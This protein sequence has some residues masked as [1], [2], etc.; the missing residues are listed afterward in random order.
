MD[1]AVQALEF[2]LSD[3]STVDHI[4]PTWL[5]LGRYWTVQVLSL[6]YA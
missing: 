2:Q 1:A 6:C 3:V 4:A 5:P